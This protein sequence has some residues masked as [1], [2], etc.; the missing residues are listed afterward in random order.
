LIAAAVRRKWPASPANQVRFHVSGSIFQVVATATK[1][2]KRG[3]TAEKAGR[4]AAAETIQGERAVAAHNL[5]MC[6]L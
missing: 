4:F 5:I 3:Q 2:D 1:A 6:T